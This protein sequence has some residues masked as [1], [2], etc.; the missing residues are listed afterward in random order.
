MKAAGSARLAVKN[1]VVFCAL[2]AV[3]FAALNVWKGSWT[4]LSGDNEAD[5]VGEPDGVHLTVD[6]GRDGFGETQT[7][8]VCTADGAPFSLLVLRADDLSVSVDGV[9]V[10][11]AMASEY[12]AVRSVPLGDVARFPESS[13]VAVTASGLYL[14]YAVYAGPADE[15]SAAVRTY[16]I[17]TVAS[18]AVFGTMLLYVLSLFA[19]KR[20]EYYLLVFAAYLVVLIVTYVIRLVYQ[21][22]ESA[23][24]YAMVIT[25]VIGAK[26]CLV[27][28]AT[29][30][31]VVGRPARPLS[32]ATA[33]AA[34]LAVALLRGAAS[35]ASMS[36]LV[37]EVTRVALVAL[38]AGVIVSA[39]TVGV[40]GALGLELGYAVFAASELAAATSPVE[41]SALFAL[42]SYTGVDELPYTIACMIFI[43]RRFAQSYG[44]SQQLSKEL[45]TLNRSLDRTVEQRTQ[46]ALKQRGL[47]HN[48]M[49]NVF[50]DLRSPLFVVKG[51]LDIL[52][53]ESAGN[54]PEKTELIEVMTDRVGFVS[55]LTED[56]FTLAKLEDGELQVALD[57]TSLSEVVKATVRAEAVAASAKGVRLLSSVE[58]GCDVWG[59]DKRLGQIVQN[60]VANAIFYTPDGG[61]VRV[62][63]SSRPASLGENGGAVGESGANDA[64]GVAR[65]SGV[66]V[67]SVSDTGPG[68]AP[69]D[70]EKIFEKYYR[71]GNNDV[72]GS[73]GLGL[74]IAKSLVE[75]HHGR[76][77]IVSEPGAG[78]TFVVEMPLAEA[79]AAE[80]GMGEA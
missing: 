68:I 49:V 48:L 60:L 75:L 12:Q 19:F 38:T 14:S 11:I 34:V 51:C 61:E 40:R 20:D 9:P 80:M 13:E 66:A 25:T 77:D 79:G 74:S 32:Y 70:R 43:N 23:P 24:S 29:Y 42:V 54:P 3:M 4:P 17:L 44:R 63:L 27:A 39:R 22:T 62:R 67:L 16:D 65:G 36:F 53:A 55:N 33:L 78:S 45:A 47:R 6:V 46:E 69:G 56:L 10:E 1:A 28:Y 30:L 8:E 15:V 52:R 21:P 73:T 72:K 31:I 64:N 58:E 41:G 5:T 57:R 2:V 76:I 59:D 35:Y 50:H 18:F 7:F 37:S 71:G 26:Y